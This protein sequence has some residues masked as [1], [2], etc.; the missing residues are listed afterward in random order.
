METIIVEKV[1]TRCTRC[2]PMSYFRMH[3]K[4]GRWIPRSR[5]KQCESGDALARQR[6]K[7]PVWT[8]PDTEKAA[9]DALGIWRGPVSREPLRAF[10]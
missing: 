10:L 3:E 5:C 6:V 7:P 4:N 2:L 1:C 9:D 8:R